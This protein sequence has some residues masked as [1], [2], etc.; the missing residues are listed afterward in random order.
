M[1]RALSSWLRHRFAGTAFELQVIV[2]FGIMVGGL[3]LFGAIAEDVLE[4][5]SHQVDETLL[6]ALRQAGDTS[7][8]IGP[9]W[10]QFAMGDMTSLG[11]Y[12]VLTLIVVLSTL[13]LLLE[14]RIR[15]A[16]LLVCSIIS[17][18][19]LISLLKLGFD[20]PRPDL[21]DHLTHASSSSFPSGHAASSALVYLT[22]GLLLA[23]AESHKRLKVFLIAS[24]IFISIL[25]GC[26]RVY[27]GVHWPS[28]VVAGWGF[29]A[30]WA[31]LWWLIARYVRTQS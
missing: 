31:I 16:L 5:E 8:P 1:I 4:G 19:L 30:A 29:G 14:H 6:L 15:T 11:G 9:A 17:G 20:R 23:Q 2:A 10:L 12:A 3:L 25:V 26:S 24:A 27:L 13:Y 18:T 28:D 22:L 21:V 7:D